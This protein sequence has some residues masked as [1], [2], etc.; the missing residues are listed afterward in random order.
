MKTR[1]YCMALDLKDD[2]Q[3]IAEYENYHRPEVIWPEI[4]TGIKACNI[5]KMDIFRAGNRLFMIMETTDDFDLKR[6][7]ERMVRLP[8]QAEWAA[9]MG[10]FQQALP[11]AGPDE[12]W[13][14]MDQIFGLEEASGK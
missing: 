5:L 12:N 4:K 11:F 13:V 7:F 8:R 14:L 10:S 3:S 1:R 6:D 2:P 9:L